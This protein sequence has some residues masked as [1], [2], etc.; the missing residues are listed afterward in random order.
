[1]LE[2]LSSVYILKTKLYANTNVPVKATMTL[3]KDLDTLITPPA[4]AILYLELFL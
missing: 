1:M 3:T 4:G 2:N